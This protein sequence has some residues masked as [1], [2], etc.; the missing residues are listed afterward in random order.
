MAVSCVIM[1][2][3][4]VISGSAWSQNG[5]VDQ[6]L[7]F[8]NGFERGGNPP[9]NRQPVAVDDDYALGGATRAFLGNNI[10]TRAPSL[11]VSDPSQGLLDNDS[12]P[13]NDPLT[14]VAFDAT[15]TSGGTVSVNADGTF[16]YVAPPPGPGS[17]TFGYTISDPAGLLATATVTINLSGQ[18]LTSGGVPITVSHVRAG[19]AGANDGTFE[20][21]FSA[22]P[23]T[24]PSDIV[25]VHADGIFN[26]QSY[27]LSAGQRFLG[28]GDG[29]DHMVMTD[30]LGAIA[31]LPG[32]GGANRPVIAD[33]AD[34]SVTAAADNE[35][36]NVSIQTPGGAGVAASG[37]TG[38]VLVNRSRFSG[39]RGIEIVN[40]AGQFTF[41]NV[42]LT[43]PANGGL[44]V[45]GGSASVTFGVTNSLNNNSAGAGVSVLNGHTGTLIFAAPINST[46]GDGLQFDNADGVYTFSGT[47][48]LNGG[49]AGI[50]ILGGSEGTFSFASTTS[51]SNPTGIAFNV[52]DLGA[53]AVIDYNGSI[54]QNLS[55]IISI[56]TTAAGSRINFNNTGANT[57]TTTNNPFGGIFIFGA[58]GDITMTTP[59]TFTNPDFSA[60][61]ATDGGGTWSFT[62]LT[63]TGQTGLNGGIDVFGQTGTVN[64]TN[65]NITTNSAGTGDGVTGF[66]AGGC[67]IINVLGNSTISA[68]GGAAIALINVNTVDIAF[69]SITTTNNTNTQIGFA[70]DDGLDI[71]GVGAGTFRVT[72]TTTVRNADG[73]GI[74]VEQTGATVTF[75]DVDLDTI[76]QD[77]II[78]GVAFDNPGIINVNGGSISNT[79]GDGVR[80]GSGS[81]GSGA[82]AFNLNDTSFTGIGGDTA[83]FSNSTL[84]GN[85]NTAAPFTCSDLGGNTGSVAF[86]GGVDSCP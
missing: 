51:I 1:F 18:V 75:A 31:L 28:E 29:N 71:L 33:S 72:G 13:D 32:S 63:I 78:S 39:G 24:Q 60:L 38:N 3:T 12:D 11:T 67:N 16:S 9:P 80:V 8:K 43:D 83:S 58:D 53:G 17:D 61:F 26:A 4:G 84:S 19:A 48:T 82:A 37:S 76:G 69:D 2:M 10:V 56:D 64:F 54:T 41:E 30:Q 62:D 46:N 74:S 44:V 25:Y 20:N 85:G 55:N 70:G 86:N 5:P 36:S 40:S 14:V 68:D 22:L 49:D 59:S 45:D 77:G 6:G 42:S 35:I 50:E 7:V 57:L 47:T 23:A 65:V 21:P 79:G 27:V 81:F 34:N 66:L 73:A 15:G 52:V